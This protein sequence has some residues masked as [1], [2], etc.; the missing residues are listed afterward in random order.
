[1]KID[2][3][4]VTSVGVQPLQISR[5]KFS[6]LYNTR[7]QST[8]SSILEGRYSRLNG[9]GSGAKVMDKSLGVVGRR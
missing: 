3:N 4:R 9:R 2:P 5:G 6:D 1:M 8:L 7:E